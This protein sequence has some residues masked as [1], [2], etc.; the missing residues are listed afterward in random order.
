MML[1]QVLSQVWIK[2]FFESFVSFSVPNIGGK[3]INKFID[4]QTINFDIGSK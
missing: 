2:L 3:T 1:P 4:N